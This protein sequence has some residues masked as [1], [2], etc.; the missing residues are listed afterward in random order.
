MRARVR[1]EKAWERGSDI[2]PSSGE[3]LKRRQPVKGGS[4]QLY[5]FMRERG[6]GVTHELAKAQLGIF[7]LDAIFGFFFLKVV[8]GT[9]M[10]RLGFA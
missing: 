9:W 6:M 10:A 8:R 1:V 5:H 2:S 3:I 7:G 4:D